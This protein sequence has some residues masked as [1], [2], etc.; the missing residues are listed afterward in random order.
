MDTASL[1]SLTSWLDGI[2]QWGELAPL[3]PVL[4]ALELLLSAD[5]AVALAAIT[6]DL[7]TEELQARALNIGISLA[8]ALR[9][10]LILAAKWVLVFWP[11]QLI[12]GMYLLYLS[13]NKLLFLSSST[14]SSSDQINV[15]KTNRSFVSVVFILCLT[16][17]A[18]SIDSVTAA[19]AIS[20][21][22]LLVI[23]GAIIG[24]IALRFTSGLFLKLLNS[25]PR[26]EVAGYL[27]VGFVGIKL[28]FT[29][30]FPKLDLPELLTFSFVL[31][32]FAWGFTKKNN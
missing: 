29:I 20:D 12:A 3:L 1:T 4:V 10:L 8:L 9:V 31:L 6:R 32:L 26:L 13:I 19:V 22:Y 11:I 18:F 17:L 15:E 28:F 27:A 14:S 2:D 7:E 30:L 5:N 21:Q 16:D 25:Y 23:T 24:V